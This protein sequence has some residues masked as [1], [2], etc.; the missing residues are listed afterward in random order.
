M[1]QNYRN[2]SNGI[3][4]Y[5]VSDNQFLYIHSWANVDIQSLYRLYMFENKYGIYIISIV[6]AGYME[7]FSSAAPCVTGDSNNI[8]RQN[9]LPL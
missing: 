5:I 6:F 7:M 3:R 9:V 8:T 2:G 4:N 1:I